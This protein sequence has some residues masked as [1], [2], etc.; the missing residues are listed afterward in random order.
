MM[1]VRVEGVSELLKRL[2]ALPV[3][4]RKNAVYSA[5][6]AGGA[7]V[8]NAAK[9]NAPYLG[10]TRAYKTLPKHRKPF[11][12]RD[13]IR[14]SRSRITK[15]QNGLYEV[16]VRVKP[17]KEKQIAAFKRA[18]V[19]AGRRGSGAANPD[20]PYYW[21]FLEFGTSKMAAQ[22][23]LRPAFESTKLAQLQAIRKRMRVSMDRIVAKL[24]AQGG[25]RRAA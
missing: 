23:F 13:A 18:Q 5:L 21:W 15:G 6:N 25:G 22:P 12:V 8:R 11:T 7:V 1:K 10:K 20:D 2:N 16:I 3:E 17:L 9:E 4:L 14:V 24:A 19:A